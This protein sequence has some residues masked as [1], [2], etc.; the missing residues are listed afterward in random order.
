MDKCWTS[1][2]LMRRTTRLC[3]RPQAVAV[4]LAVAVAGLGATPAVAAGPTTTAVLIAADDLPVALEAESAVLSGGAGVNDNHEGYSGTGFVDGFIL[5]N[6]GTASVTFTLVVPAAG[7]YG[8]NLRYANGTGSDMTITQDTGAAARQITLPSAPGAGW[9]FWSVHQEV[10][11]LEAGEQQVTYRYAS[12]DTGNVNLD[13]MALAAVGDLSTP[14]GGATDPDELGE[15]GPDTRWDDV[16]DVLRPLPGRRSTAFQ[17]ED[18]FFANGAEQVAWRG[19]D[20]VDMSRE[21]A[22]LVVPVVVRSSGRQLVSVRYVNRSGAPADVVVG[23]DGIPQG[24]LVL[25]AGSSWQD[26]AVRLP[27]SK[28][29]GSVELRRTGNTLEPGM[30]VDSVMLRGG[31]PLQERGATVATTTYQAERGRTDGDVLEPSRAFHDVAAEASGRQAVRLAS[32][33]DHVEW[34]L[35]EP[36]NSLVLRASIPDTA[37]GTGQVGSLGVYADGRKVSDIDVSSE[38]AY[39]YGDYPYVN[40]PS[41]GG[42]QRFFDETRVLLDE[43]FPTGTVLRLA[44]DAASADL[45]YTVDLAE[46]EVVADPLTAPEGYVDVR[47]LGATSDDGTDDTAA[48]EAAVDRARELGTGVWVPEGRFTLGSRLRVEGVSVRGAGPWRS[49]VEGRDGHGGFY[50]TGSG[51]TIADLMVDGDVRYRDDADFDAAMEGDFGQGSL[52]QNVWVEHTKV[53]LWASS[54]TDGLYALGL[55]IRDVFADGVHFNGRVTDSRVEHTVVRN[56][57][58]DA[59]AMWSSGGSVTRSVFARNTVQ[60]PLLANGAALYGGTSN[61][62]ERNVVMDTLTASAGIAVSTRFNPVPFAGT[63]VVEGNTVLRSG[64]WEPNWATSFGGIWVFA[65]TSAITS[66]VVI[67]GTDVVDSTYEGVL[68]SGNHPVEDLR[69]EDVTIDGAGSY[70]VAIRVGG[71]HR[72]TDVHATGVPADEEGRRS[73]FW[74]QLVDGGGNTGLW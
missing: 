29:L 73:Q 27:L 58:D 32:E 49:V 36:T 7:E 63:T 51:V 70:G 6:L 59:M 54:G 66:P 52:L 28:G 10:V 33:G 41:L 44:K 25:P 20:G 26:V 9:D 21:R 31:L 53:G 17:A 2:T 67:R 4:V 61:R 64:G 60:N 45:P 42:A 47:D 69:I 14:G 5:D 38:F 62:I 55:R 46:T 19:D 56:T 8:L 3:A 74:G 43:E 35:T 18:A 40:D 12:T 65:D 37:D 71:V 24:R 50:A 30:V 1:W 39:V 16:T 48:F 13:A 72:L 11:E 34:E 23:V 57:G 15:S 68:V 22:R